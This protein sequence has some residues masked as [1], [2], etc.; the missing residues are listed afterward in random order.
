MRPPSFD[1]CRELFLIGVD[2]LFRIELS[3]GLL[4]LESLASNCPLIS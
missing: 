2:M 4:Q 3:I 1:V